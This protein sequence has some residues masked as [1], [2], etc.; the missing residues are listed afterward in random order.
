MV[1]NRISME[2]VGGVARIDSKR[3]TK[4]LAVRLAGL[5]GWELLFDPDALV[6]V[7][8]RSEVCR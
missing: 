6:K 5:S 3:P 7:G 2:E 1:V 8:H 4:P